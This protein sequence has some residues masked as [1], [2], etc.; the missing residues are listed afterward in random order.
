[1]EEFAENFDEL[2]PITFSYWNSDKPEVINDFIKKIYFSDYSDIS[3]ITQDAYMNLTDVCIELYLCYES[4]G[5]KMILYE[6]LV[7][8]VYSDVYFTVGIDETL[9]LMMPKASKDTFF[10]YFTFRGAHSFS[11]IFGDPTRNYGERIELQ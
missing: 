7:F 8:Q 2:A 3:K 5:Y 11:E 6:F 4:I 1:M 10:Y 9:G